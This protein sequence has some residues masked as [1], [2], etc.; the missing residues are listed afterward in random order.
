ML[1]AILQF[2]SSQTKILRVEFPG[3]LPVRWGFHPLKL[4]PD[5]V[6]SKN[7]RDLSQNDNRMRIQMN[8]C[9]RNE[10]D[11]TGDIKQLSAGDSAWNG[12]KPELSWVERSR[13]LRRLANALSRDVGDSGCSSPQAAVDCAELSLVRGC[14]VRHARVV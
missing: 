12:L 5:R 14:V 10:Q 2:N 9:M 8:R 11:P 7:M 6:E 3:G 4:D 13:G 1:T